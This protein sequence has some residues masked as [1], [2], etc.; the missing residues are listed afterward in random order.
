MRRLPSAVRSWILL[1]ETFVSSSGFPVLTALF[2]VYTDLSRRLKN[3]CKE[4]KMANKINTSN[5]VLRAEDVAAILCTSVPSA[6]KII[7][8]LNLEQQAKGYL[9]VPGRVNA[10]YFEERFGIRVI[11]PEIIDV[12]NMKEE[13]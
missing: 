8:K 2:V 3:K 13:E 5:N 11:V 6:Y 12:T 9:F 7:K 1:L 10:R 4:A